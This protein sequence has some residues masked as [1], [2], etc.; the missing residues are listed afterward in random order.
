MECLFS[1]TK[2]IFSNITPHFLGHRHTFTIDWHEDGFERVKIFRIMNESG[3][4]QRSNTESKIWAIE[5][6]KS[7]CRKGEESN[8]FMDEMKPL[9]VSLGKKYTDSIFDFHG[10]TVTTCSVDLA[11]E[12][13]IH[14]LSCQS[15]KSVA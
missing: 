1:L 12:F 3:T 2:P 15:C 8:M 5:E 4:S 14:I 6:S 9:K 7:T 13:N 10:E 11:Q